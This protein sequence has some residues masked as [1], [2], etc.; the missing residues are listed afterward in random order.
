[1]NQHVTD[2]MVV[3]IPTATNDP[4]VLAGLT[5]AGNDVTQL[6]RQ[7]MLKAALDSN[8]AV[9]YNCET[10][11][12]SRMELAAAMDMY[13]KQPKAIALPQEQT[14]GEADPILQLLSTTPAPSELSLPP[15]KWK[16]LLRNILRG[17]NIMMT[18]PSGSGKSVTAKAAAGAL[19]RPFFYFNLGATQDPRSTLIGNMH[20]DKDSGT[21]FATSLFA[22]AIQTPDAVILLDELSRAHPEAWNILMSVLD[23]NQRYLRLDE[24]KDITTIRVAEGVSFIAT[25][26]IGAAYTATRAMDRALLDRF[27]IVEMDLLDTEAESA[28]LKQRY[29]QVSSTDITAIAAIADA[30]RKEVKSEAPKLSSA[31]STRLT[32]EIAAHMQDGFTL[33]EAVETCIYP[34]YDQEGGID[35]ERTY[36]KQLVQKWAGEPEAATTPF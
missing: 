32:Q 36:I 29:P 27:T 24:D 2:K 1:M 11:R 8:Q 20:Y 10:A 28:L 35:S 23:T 22:Q 6:T 31:I 33:L 4:R 7:V 19:A 14:A 13:N 5:P 21:V 25:A 15:I 17:R 16:Y 30:T 9:I 18:G 26:N 3:I 34:F 12:C